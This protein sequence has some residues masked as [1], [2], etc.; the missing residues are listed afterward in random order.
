MATSGYNYQKVKK[1]LLEFE[2]IDPV[3]LALQDKP[4][5][6]AKH[7]CK[8]YFNSPFEP[9]VPHPRK[10]ISKNYDILAKSE[11]ASALFPRENLIASSR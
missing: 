2:K 10:I 1:E 11:K 8:A 3:D 9:R 6:K 5:K 4:K 7:G